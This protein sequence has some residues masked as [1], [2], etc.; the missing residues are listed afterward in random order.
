MMTKQIPIALCDPES[1]EARTALGAYYAELG[2]RLA[3]G[4]DVTK[5][6]DPEAD[7]LRPPVGAF[8]LARRESV[9]VGC[10]GLKGSDEGA[11]IK[12]LWVADGARRQGLARRLMDTA[13][14]EARAIG[15]DTLRL[16]TNSALPEAIAMYRQWGWREIPRYNSDP[17]AEVFFEKVL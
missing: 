17:Y 6:R 3:M 7:A 11:E 2:R 5:S 13:E 9:P 4:F 15:Y 1:T 16:D 10:V 12:R 8:F 14:A